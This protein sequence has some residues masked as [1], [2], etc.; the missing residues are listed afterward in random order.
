MHTL[1]HSLAWAGCSGWHSCSPFGGGGLEVGRAAA[2][3]VLLMRGTLHPGGGDIQVPKVT[4]K[5]APGSL[6]LAAKRLGSSG[7][8]GPQS[9]STR[10]GVLLVT[11]RAGRGTRPTDTSCSL[12][13]SSQR[14]RLHRTHAPDQ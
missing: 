8:G 1:G 11:S 10:L 5:N 6:P 12:R 3:A 4:T 2:L 13:G 14:P 7:A 9:Y